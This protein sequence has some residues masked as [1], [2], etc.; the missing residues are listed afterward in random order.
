MKLTTARAN[1]TKEPIQG[2]VIGQV[3][4][5]SNKN[6]TFENDI[7][8]GEIFMIL[9]SNAPKESALTSKTM[10]VRLSEKF[11]YVTRTGPMFGYT[12]E[13]N[14]N[15]SIDKKETTLEQLQPGDGVTF[16]SD[17]DE[18]EYLIITD[19]VDTTKMVSLVNLATCEL[20]KLSKE[21][22]CYRHSI[23]MVIK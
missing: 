23:Q 10:F 5:F 4:R 3:F 18:N 14:L 15:F 13:D 22:E 16:D 19:P 17:S 8:N 6:S 9:S 1:G 12:L 7:I 20:I 11:E 21:S 2:M